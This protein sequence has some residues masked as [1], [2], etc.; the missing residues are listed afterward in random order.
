MTQQQL[1]DDVGV[2][3]EMVSRYERGDS[4]PLNRIEALAKALSVSPLELLQEY[5]KSSDTN[6]L[7][8]MIN[9]VPLF[10]SVPSS[11]IFT[12]AHTHYFYNAPIWVTQR[13]SEA[14]AIEQRAFTSKTSRTS[15]AAVLYIS[16]NATISEDSIVL[17]KEESNLACDIS[18]K[19]SKPKNIIGVVVAQEVRM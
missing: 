5:Y 6:A 9:N 11:L 19:V 12:K 1:A 13:D 17:Y 16:P 14:F 8:S 4:S 18:S 7:S 10:T 3:W 2:T 15:E